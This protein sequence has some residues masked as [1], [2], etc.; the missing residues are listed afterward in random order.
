MLY[1]RSWLSDYIDLKD[2]TDD[3][4]KHIITMKSGEVE[5]V[6]PVS[7]YFDS[8]VLIGKIENL[9]KHPDA[10]RL[11]IFDVDLGKKGKIQI[12]SAA[13]N[14]TD[15]LLVVVANVGA[16]LAMGTILEREMRGQK[17]QGMCVGMS[18]LLLETQYSSGLWEIEDLILAKKLD[19]NSILGESVCTVLPEFFPKD[20]IYDIKYLADKISGCGNHLG[21]AVEIA[22][23]LEKPEL[24]TPLAQQHLDPTFLAETILTD[25][26]L[27]SS[28]L[29]IRLAD[30]SNY[31]GSFF[32][33][34]LQF[35]QHYLLPHQ[36]QTRMFLTERN[37]VGGVADLSNYLLYDIGQPTHFFSKDRVLKLNQGRTVLDWQIDKLTESTHFEGLGQLKSVAIPEG[38]DVLKQANTILT[39]PAISGSEH[40]KIDEKDKQILVEIASFPAENVARSCFKLNYRSEAARIWAGSVQSSLQF[41][42]LAKLIQILKSSQ[43]SY[44]LTSILNYVSPELAKTHHISP[45][46]NLLQTATKIFDTHLNNGIK[47]DLDYIANRLDA[48]GTEYWS[49]IIIQK[50]KIIGTYSAGVLRPSIFYQPVQ[51]IDDVLEQVSRLI[52]YDS[53]ATQPLQTQIQTHQDKSFDKLN[54]LKGV[55]LEYG[56]YESISR[57]F[58]SKTGMELLNPANSNDIFIRDNLYASLM[59]VVAKNIFAGEKDVRIFEQTKLYSTNANQLLEKPV[60]EAILLNSDPYIFT[61]LIHTLAQKIGILEYTH[62]ELDSSLQ[63]FGTGYSYQ[64]GEISLNLIKVSNKH[65]RLYDIPLTKDVWYLAINMEK[66]SGN[67]NIYPKYH[68]ESE[69]STLTRHYSYMVTKDTQ[70]QTIQT[71][72]KE[73][74]LPEVQMRI[75]PLERLSQDEKDVLNYRVD[76]VSYSKNLEGVEVDKW[77]QDL[78]KKSKGLLVAR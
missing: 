58:V 78:V 13:P 64:L 11:K 2:Y 66:W 5:D 22:T 47:V 30:K 27:Q 1:L 62:Q 41:V 56:F 50:L 46:D 51:T 14:S 20:T 75:H 68:N 73:S 49:E 61:S 6:L 16:K 7:D 8:K 36:L 24:L 67:L 12:V 70:W 35:E 29:T 31:S 57:P 37:L 9:R 43:S 60:I 53:L 52:G 17:S 21:L 19:P 28:D 25:V 77:E 44:S 48:Q 4:L 71:L 10:D 72:I 32:L 63:D 42:V 40:T 54:N 39:I 76:F 69:Y 23:C 3:E 26:Q 65:K 59:Q 55:F 15:G 38:V 74:V 34:D 18:E 45:T 33:F